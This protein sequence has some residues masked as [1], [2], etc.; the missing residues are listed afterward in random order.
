MH[1]ISALVAAAPD[2]VTEHL[3][4]TGLLLI[5]AKRPGASREWLCH[6]LDD[7]Q[8]FV[9]A[10]RRHAAK[11]YSKTGDSDNEALEPSG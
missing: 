9:A 5:V 8:R 7:D 4:S 3:D 6:V 1:Q 2:G 11:W 10:L